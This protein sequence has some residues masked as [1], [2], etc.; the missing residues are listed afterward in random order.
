MLKKERTAAIIIIIWLMQ[1][2]VWKCCWIISSKRGIICYALNM[3]LFNPLL[4]F[5]IQHSQNPDWRCIHNHWTIDAFQLHFN[6]WMLKNKN[7]KLKIFGEYGS[8]V[9]FF[10]RNYSYNPFFRAINFCDGKTCAR[11]DNMKILCKIL[12][13]I[14]AS[15]DF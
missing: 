2:C 12:A 8:D 11:C 10:P 3:H 5:D 1:I 4:M 15:F 7:F 13:E 9:D 14:F 6:W